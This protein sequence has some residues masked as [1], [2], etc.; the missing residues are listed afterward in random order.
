MKQI[1]SMHN[2]LFPNH[3][4]EKEFDNFLK[5]ENEIIE[6]LFGNSKYFILNTPVVQKRKS[7][8]EIIDLKNKLG[9]VHD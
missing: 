7:K 8:Q 2:F 3:K 9:E 1:I 5:K 6:S 4:W